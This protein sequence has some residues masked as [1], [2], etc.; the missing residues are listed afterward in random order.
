MQMT[1]NIGYVMTMTQFFTHC[2]RC[3]FLHM[4]Q[5]CKRAKKL[6]DYCPRLPVQHWMREDI[7][8]AEDLRKAIN[9][10]DI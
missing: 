5:E 9:Y 10:L 6:R 3:P 2:N 1:G 4:P 7:D 8:P